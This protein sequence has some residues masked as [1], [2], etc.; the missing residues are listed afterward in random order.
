MLA[1]LQVYKQNQVSAKSSGCSN[2]L[3]RPTGGNL[4]YRIETSWTP[5]II[6]PINQLSW[7]VC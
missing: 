2:K 3:M 6:S 4:A 1:V 7:G 5:P